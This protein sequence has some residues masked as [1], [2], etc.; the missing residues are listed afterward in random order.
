MS[1]CDGIGGCKRDVAPFRFASG[2]T[3]AIGKK[4]VDADISDE[5]RHREHRKPTT[6]CGRSVAL[7]PRGNLSRPTSHVTANA[8]RKR[9]AVARR[10]RFRSRRSSDDDLRSRRRRSRQR[11][12]LSRHAGSQTPAPPRRHLLPPRQPVRLPPPALDTS[13]IRRRRRRPTGQWRLATIS[14]DTSFSSLTTPSLLRVILSTFK[15]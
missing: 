5:Q 1:Y 2:A 11:G 8:D 7:F 6:R 13:A 12:R 14:S 4:A 15:S 9:C 3:R 10:R